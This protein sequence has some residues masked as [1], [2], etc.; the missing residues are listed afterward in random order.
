MALISK[1]FIY[2][3]PDSSLH[4]TNKKKKQCNTKN[5]E[6]KFMNLKQDYHYTID[7][8]VLLLRDFVAHCSDLEDKIESLEDK[9]L[10]Q[11]KELIRV[12]NY[13]YRHTFNSEVLVPEFPDESGKIPVYID[14]IRVDSPVYIDG[15]K[16]DRYLQVEEP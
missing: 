10:S 12:R 11:E 16:V 15:I 4:A 6:N 3:F 9:I 8:F 7:S 13:I 5:I 14:G 1:L 2:T